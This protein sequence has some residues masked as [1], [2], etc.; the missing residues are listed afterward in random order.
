MYVRY[1]ELQPFAEEWDLVNNKS[2]LRKC[3]KQ[4]LLKLSILLSANP[5]PCLK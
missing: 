4:R 3:G 5:V 2:L 1:V